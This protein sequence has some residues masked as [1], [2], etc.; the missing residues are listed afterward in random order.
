M[1]EEEFEFLN[2]TSLE[3][4]DLIER[5]LKKRSGWYNEHRELDYEEK[6]NT[7]D[8]RTDREQLHLSHTD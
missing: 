3:D 4:I 6:D 7:Y 2:E 5:S 1:T 8:T